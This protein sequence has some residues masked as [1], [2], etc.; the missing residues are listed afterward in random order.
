MGGEGKNS[1]LSVEEY[2]DKIKPYLSNMINNHK[3]QGTWR[4]YSGNTRIK[5]KTQSE[6][7]IQLTLK[8]NF[9]S[10]L[11]DSDETRIMHARSDNTEIMMSIETEEVIKDVFE[12]LLK[13][14]EKQ[15]AK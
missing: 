12:S 5:C 4:I 11:Q 2:L 3:T 9:V 15:L 1:N 6:W 7:K 14:Y 13:R 8:V 10:F